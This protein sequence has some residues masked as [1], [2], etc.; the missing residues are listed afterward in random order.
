MAGESSGG[1]PGPGL[2][3]RLRADLAEVC[4]VD[5]TGLPDELV[6]AEVLD[7]IACLNQ[8]TAALTDRVGSFDVRCLSESDA[9]RTTR[10]WLQLYGHLSQG[11]AAGLLGR[12]RLLRQLPA[13]ASAFREGLISAEHLAKV[14]ELA[15]HV[16]I[17]AVRAFDEV[18]ASLAA[19]AGPGEVAKA[20]QRILAYLDP[21]GADPDPDA[22]LRKRELT[23]SRSGSMLL[24]RGTFDPEGGAALVAAWRR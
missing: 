10:H 24:V 8:V 9:G 23:F 18:L 7:L 14:V 4:A 22:D 1:P 13:L 19:Q 16:G 6:R 5:V 15:E 21:D 12:A 3:E 17:E 11:A 2:I 20:C